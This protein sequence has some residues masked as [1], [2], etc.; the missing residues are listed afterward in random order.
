MV[1]SQRPVLQ[2][3][4]LKGP[5]LAPPPCPT[6]LVTGKSSDRR[7]SRIC[8]KCWVRRFLIA[9]ER[10]EGA[11][12]SEVGMRRKEAGTRA[13]GKLGAY[14]PKNRGQTAGSWGARPDGIPKSFFSPAGR[15]PVPAAAVTQPL[16]Q[17]ETRSTRSV[18]LGVRQ[19]VLRC[20]EATHCVQA[21][22]LGL[23]PTEPPGGIPASFPFAPLQVTQSP[24]ADSLPLCLGFCLLGDPSQQGPQIPFCFPFQNFSTVPPPTLH[25]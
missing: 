25:L 18:S 1:K 22:C 12:A 19:G 14:I 7:T 13:I 2:W 4:D 11:E 6:S 17:V 5:P 21:E 16:N 8:S 24:G 9:R 10:G 3:K 23:Y 20:S 15:P